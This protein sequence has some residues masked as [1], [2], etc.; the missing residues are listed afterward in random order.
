MLKKLCLK[1]PLTDIEYNDNLLSK[2]KFQIPT[3]KKITQNTNSEKDD[4]SQICDRN[5]KSIF[6]RIKNKNKNNKYSFNSYQYM[7]QKATIF[8]NKNNNINTNVA[9]K[10]SNLTQKNSTIKKDIKN[11]NLT[12]SICPKNKD[13][14][15]K[16]NISVCDNLKQ[17]EN[18]KTIKEIRI[19]SNKKLSQIFPLNNK[20]INNDEKIMTISN[21]NNE[22][23]NNN[24]HKK[25]W[26]T[27][28]IGIYSKKKLNAFKSFSSISMEK[29]KANTIKSIEIDFGPKIY[30]NSYTDKKCVNPYKVAKIIMIQRYFRKFLEIKNKK[31][32]KDKILKGIQH[33][34]KYMLYNLS[35]SIRKFFL[36]YLLKKNQRKNKKVWL[37]KKEQYELLK[38]LREKNISGM[39]NLK[40][41]IVRLLNSGKLE[42][43]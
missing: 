10:V 17:Y 12:S 30:R 38:I 5:I 21:L 23:R 42:L 31:L 2:R 34:K 11:M 4:I 29:Q 13:K 26:E 16:R 7:K 9:K 32:I 35:T 33:L 40:K 43:F 28:R 41:Y 19:K 20:S 37:V 22:D 15:R 27:S 36:F 25:F 14:K 18:N 39:K 24:K 1:N 8:V 3:A 6:A